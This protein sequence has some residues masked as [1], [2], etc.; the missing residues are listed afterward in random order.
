MADGVPGYRARLQ[1][2][3]P[4]P[5][6]SPYGTP[7]PSPTSGDRIEI[8]LDNRGGAAVRE[9]AQK[10]TQRTAGG[11]NRPGL[12]KVGRW[13]VPFSID[14]YL[15]VSQAP[16]LLA[17]AM[18][19]YVPVGGTREILPAYTFYT[20]DGYGYHKFVGG[21]VDEVTISS[22]AGSD[23]VRFRA[24]GMCQKEI[25]D[26]GDIPWTSAIF[27]TAYAQPS[28]TCYIHQNAFGH[29]TAAGVALSCRS[30]TVRVR[31]VN[32]HRHMGSGFIERNS[33][34]GRDVTFGLT[35]YSDDD[36]FYDIF[37][38]QTPGQVSLGWY[39][40]ANHAVITSNNIAYLDSHERTTDIATDVQETHL[41]TVHED[42]GTAPDL[43]LDVV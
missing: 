9:M 25:L 37:H 7:K 19:P 5:D 28:G 24:T 11:R 4:E 6:T 42:A 33:F 35:P 32:D 26:T 39:I 29:V 3:G 10:V 38:D 20:D 22:E 14:T 17:W 21:R 27:P 16:K 36:T 13:T 43:T 2:V 23:F 1:L 31:N 18:G 12:Q 34:N 40:G 30:I 15:Y 8:V 41:W